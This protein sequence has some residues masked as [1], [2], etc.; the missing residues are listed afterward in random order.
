MKSYNTLYT[1]YYEESFEDA[2]NAGMPESDAEERAAEE[3]HCKA[4]DYLDG[5]G[6]Y[7]LMQRQEDN[8]EKK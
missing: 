7:K 3:A 5:Y 6:D 4:N 8:Y 2:I 1:E